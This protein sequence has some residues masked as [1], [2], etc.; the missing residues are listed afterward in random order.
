MS[1]GLTLNVPVAR[2]RYDA[3]RQKL[4][5]PDFDNG[6]NGWLV[7]ET[8]DGEVLFASSQVRFVSTAS[9]DLAQLSQDVLVVGRT[10]LLQA[11]LTAR[12]SGSAIWRNGAGGTIGD[13]FFALGLTE[14]TFTATHT[15]IELRR[16]AAVSDFTIAWARV[17]EQ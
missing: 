13:S 9:G 10:Y 14:R 7:T 16:N 2:G 5:N 12:V 4:V 15:L 11:Y 1:S 3:G 8:E 6:L 17:I